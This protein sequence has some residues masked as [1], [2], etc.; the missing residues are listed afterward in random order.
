MA[1][2]ENNND[3]N[4]PA[5]SGAM[6]ASLKRSNREIKDDRAAVIS[7]DSETSYRR[8]VEDIEKYIRNMDRNRAGALDLSPNNVFSL[9]LA[10]SFNG[11]KFCEDDLELSVK[12][13]NEKIKLNIAK[14]RYNYL[15]GHKFEL[16]KL[17]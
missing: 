2:D 17:D 12:I 1:T 14:E 8:K 7:E 11:E 9:Q 6:L 13:R 4:Q 5:S 3:N 15:F 16:E 10:N